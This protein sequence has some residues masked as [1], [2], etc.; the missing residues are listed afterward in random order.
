MPQDFPMTASMNAIKRLF[1]VHKVDIKFSLPFCTLIDG[2]SESEHLIGK[3][4]FFPK[5][6]LFF[7]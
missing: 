3:T 2:V 4:L 6:S 7:T 5:S 1:K